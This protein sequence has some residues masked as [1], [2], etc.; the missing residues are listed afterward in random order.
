M[1]KKFHLINKLNNNIFTINKLSKNLF[2]QN[3][4][5]FFSQ[6]LHQKKNNNDNYT[7]LTAPSFM[8][9]KPNRIQRPRKRSYATS[10]KTD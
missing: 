2:A 1:H 3:L 5:Q 8:F 7:S 9:D 4:S 10:A 6:Q